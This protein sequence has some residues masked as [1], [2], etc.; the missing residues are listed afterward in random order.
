MK[1]VRIDRILGMM[2]FVVV[3]VFAW[4]SLS[5]IENWV[6]ATLTASPA[7]IFTQTPTIGNLIGMVCWVSC[8]IV[9]AVSFA[10]TAWLLFLILAPDIARGL[11]A[12]IRKDCE[13]RVG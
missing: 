4:L 6:G 10:A 8:Y 12:R 9:V 7:T 11:I 5:R 3:G 1:G 13:P 2:L